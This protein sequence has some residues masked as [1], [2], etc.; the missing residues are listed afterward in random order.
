MPP[1]VKTPPARSGS[2][3]TSR[4]VMPVAS[5]SARATRR[6]YSSQATL[7]L[8]SAASMTPIR[9][10]IVGGGMTFCWVRGWPKMVMPRR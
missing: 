6:L 10:G 3:S 5:T 7:G 1:K 9:L 8:W 2:Y 4:A